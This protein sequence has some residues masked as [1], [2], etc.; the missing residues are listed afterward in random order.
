MHS[1]G[2]LLIKNMWFYCFGKL[3]LNQSRLFVVLCFF[4]FC[5][6]VAVNCAL[7][8]V[9][10]LC[11]VLTE[12]STSI[13]KQCSSESCQTC[14][15]KK[16]ENHIHTS[17]SVHDISNHPFAM[18]W[19]EKKGVTD[20]SFDLIENLSTNKFQLFLSICKNGFYTKFEAT[21]G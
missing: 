2:L 14:R 16:M 10:Q 8:L 1:F 13:L 6:K 21:D 12:I 11:F 3:E 17:Y 5:Q 19:G 15:L 4:P 18:F 20:G 7:S 9:A